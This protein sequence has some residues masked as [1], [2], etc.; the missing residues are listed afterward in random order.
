M[1]ALSVTTAAESCFESDGSLMFLLLS[2][3]KSNM[4]T[5]PAALTPG[6]GGG[7]GSILPSLD[8]EPLIT[9]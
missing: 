2:M 5:A 4:Q 6:E 8:S 3:P 7:C 1:E 9:S